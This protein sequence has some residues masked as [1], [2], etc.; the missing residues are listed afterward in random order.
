MVL[1][2]N[3][4]ITIKMAANT[5]KLSS[6][7][8]RSNVMTSYIRKGLRSIRLIRSQFRRVL[9]QLWNA[10][11]QRGCHARP[12]AWLLGR[13][14]RRGAVRFEV[15]SRRKT[16]IHSR[17]GSFSCEGARRAVHPRTST[18]SITRG[19]NPGPSRREEQVRRRLS[20]STWIWIH[21]A[22]VHYSHYNPNRDLAMGQT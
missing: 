12:S 8:S 18:P 3:G 20:P 17:P 10:K 2:N 22:V 14:A 1:K 16:P 15:G 13:G 19:R 11:D 4:C 21:P 6:S 5:K 9:S 7:T